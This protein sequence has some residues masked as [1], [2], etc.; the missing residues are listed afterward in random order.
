MSVLSPPAGRPSWAAARP[1]HLP[2]MP[3]S[4]ALNPSHQ[5]LTSL[6]PETPPPHKPR[7]M[8]KQ[9]LR[10]ALC[11]LL[12]LKSSTAS[13][14]KPSQW[15]SLDPS[16]TR[17][18]LESNF[19]RG[20][21]GASTETLGSTE[22]KTSYDLP[23]ATV[24]L[25]E[26]V[27]TASTRAGGGGTLSVATSGASTSSA[28]PSTQPS[29]DSSFTVSLAKP[30]ESPFTMATL[31]S[32]S[33][34]LSTMATLVSESASTSTT[35]ESG[36]RSASPSTTSTIVSFCPPASGGQTSSGVMETRLPPSKFGSAAPPTYEKMGVVGVLG[37]AAGLFMV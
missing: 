35:S 22:T 20:H 30:T 25:S 23:T 4:T 11:S 28:S 15:A 37:A 3:P 16:S 29:S 19:P 6:V 2:N 33:A 7:T 10:T 13:A 26:R 8:R 31:A 32:E 12:G 5:T 36:S 18:L 34:G 17:A 14:Q 9:A 27:Y 24:Y 1:T 21:D